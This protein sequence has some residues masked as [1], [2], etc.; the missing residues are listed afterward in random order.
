MPRALDLGILTIVAVCSS[1]C[2]KPSTVSARPDAAL[3]EGCLRD[4]RVVGDDEATPLGPANDIAALA[5]GEWNV[6]TRWRELKALR[7][8]HEGQDTRLNV[9]ITRRA[10]PA[11]YVVTRA[12][13][14]PD[15]NG[16]SGAPMCFNVLELP[17][18]VEASTHD[19]V[20][21]LSFDTLLQA[22]DAESAAV[23]H[24]QPLKSHRGNLKLSELEPESLE[25]NDFYFSL[26]FVREHRDAG[27]D[28][29]RM[30]GQ[31]RGVYRAIEGDTM[32]GLYL[33]YLCFPRGPM[34]QNNGFFPGC[35]E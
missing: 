18:H 33:D 25:A 12:N 30:S 21:K 31:M 17:V 11:K 16:P 20:L 27:A 1:A 5:V 2:R 4:E 28:E 6:Q 24:T 29:R 13:P 35:Q 15:P 14:A 22:Q 26:G 10:G 32:M 9:R 7:Y 19:G 8:P 34:T 3:Y 23:Y